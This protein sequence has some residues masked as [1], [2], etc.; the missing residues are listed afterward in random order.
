MSYIYF[1]IKETVNKDLHR[2]VEFFFRGWVDDVCDNRVEIT[3]V[4]QKALYKVEFDHNED[5]LVV[6]L[7][8]LPKEFIK[9]LEI[10]K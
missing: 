8:G 1:K 5:A 10:V 7:K 6:H 4:E 3:E 2:I 9:Y